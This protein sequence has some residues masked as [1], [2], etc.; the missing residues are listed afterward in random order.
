MPL[1]RL[2]RDRFARTGRPSRPGRLADAANAGGRAA[3]AAQFISKQDADEAE[4][5]LAPSG[6]DPW[7]IGLSSADRGQG[8]DESLRLLHCSAHA[9]APRARA[10]NCDSGELEKILYRLGREREAVLLNQ[11]SKE[12]SWLRNTSNA[13][14]NRRCPSLVLVVFSSES[15]E[16]FGT[17]QHSVKYFGLRTRRGSE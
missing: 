3:S 13:L 10:L 8:A 14:G 9:H 1:F 7:A 11:S 16:S 5:R 12:G 15:Q 17:R 2:A 6:L 4:R